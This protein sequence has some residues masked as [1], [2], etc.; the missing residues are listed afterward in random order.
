MHFANIPSHIPHFNHFSLLS[1]RR[2]RSPSMHAMQR[3]S[4]RAILSHHRGDIASRKRHHIAFIATQCDMINAVE[5]VRANAVHKLAGVD[6]DESDDAIVAASDATVFVVLD[7]T[8]EIGRVSFHTV[9]VPFK[10]A[11][12]EHIHHARRH[13]AA[14]LRAILHETQRQDLV[15]QTI[16][17]RFQRLWMHLHRLLLSALKFLKQFIAFAFIFTSPLQQF[18]LRQV[19]AF[20]FRFNRIQIGRFT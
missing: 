10:P 17:H 15:A 11:P 6:G 8:A 1:R 5:F 9:L 2:R 13:T 20:H 12:R 3:C 16:A 19:L 14:Q 18:T 4:I 7:E